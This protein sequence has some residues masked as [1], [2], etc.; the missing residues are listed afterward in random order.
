MQESLQNIRRTTNYD[1]REQSFNI[2]FSQSLLLGK[3]KRK[4]KQERGRYSGK[5]KIEYLVLL[6]LL[7]LNIYNT[8]DSEN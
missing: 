8:Q 2:I 3:E 5:E 4:G 7:F 6:R 1:N